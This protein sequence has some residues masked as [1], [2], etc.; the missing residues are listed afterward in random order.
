MSNAAPLMSMTIRAVFSLG[1]LALSFL[2]IPAAVA[3]QERA[4]PDFALTRL[5]DGASV[6]SA[7]LARDDQW[8]VVVV[9][10]ACEPCR[11]VVRRLSGNGAGVEP[12]RV[13][14]VMSGLTAAD[15]R[16]LRVSAPGLAATTWYVDSGGAAIEALSV[17]NAPA[18]FGVRNDRIVWALRGS[19]FIDAQWQG[20]VVPWLR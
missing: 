9:R 10:P 18:L 5:A 6:S 3:A 20:V 19:L 8:V 15:A 1:I 7:I 16:A 17:R 14:V 11:A 2:L 4:W 12:G 13:V